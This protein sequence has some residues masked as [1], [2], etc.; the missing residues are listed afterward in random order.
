MEEW[1]KIEGYNGDYEISNLGRVKSFKLDHEMG[2]IL[3]PNCDGWGYY[4]VVLSKNGE[5]KR[6]KIHRLVAK[7]FVENPGNKPCVNHINGAKRDNMADN[8][9]WCTRSE[10][11][12]HAFK[13]G[14]KTQRGEQNSCSKLTEE[15]VREI[16]RLLNKGEKMLVIAREFGVSMSCI[17]NIKRGRDWVF[18]TV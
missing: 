11:D 2:K 3:K 16:K 8:L 4:A 12:K 7:Y 17:N 6:M 9:E 14:L 18:V 5:T 1:K 13:I 10:N 15:K